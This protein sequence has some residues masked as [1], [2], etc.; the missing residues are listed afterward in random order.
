MYRA[1]NRKSDDREFF[2]VLFLT[3]SL[4]SP[5]GIL[6]TAP[7][8]VDRPHLRGLWLVA[9]EEAGAALGGRGPVFLVGSAPWPGA[10][11]PMSGQ[12]SPCWGWQALGTIGRDSHFNLQFGNRRSQL[13]IL[14]ALLFTTAVPGLALREVSPRPKGAPRPSDRVGSPSRPHRGSRN[15]G[16]K[17]LAFI[18][19]P[20]LGRTEP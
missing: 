6:Q 8:G 13:A 16:A 20:G 10:C 17:A 7:L 11:G 1:I 3:L 4:Q 14:P 12:G 19:A 18:L 15:P 5:M 9:G 2:F